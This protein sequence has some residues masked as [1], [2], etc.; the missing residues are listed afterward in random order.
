[1]A[2]ERG[3]RRGYRVATF[4][5]ENLLHPGVH[6][7]GRGDEA[8]YTPELFADKVRW[9]ASL[10]DEGRVDLVGFQ[11]LF[12][13]TAL[14][15]VVAASRRLRGA[16]V[17]TPGITGGENL[18]TRAD[19]GVEASGPH[20]GL[21]T[22]FPVL[23]CDSVEEFPPGPGVALH[24]GRAAGDGA[25]TRFQRPVLRA[26]VVLPG[27]VPATVL[28]AH[29]K[30]K[31]PVHLTGEDV[32][33]PVVQAAGRVRALLVRAA[34]AV[35]LRALV[36]ALLDGGRAGPGAGPA[37]GPVIL[38]GDLNDDLAAVTTRLVAGEEPPHHLP[39]ER[40][41]HVAGA[42]LHSAHDLQELRNYRDVSY[43]H[44]HQGR[45][46]LLDHVFVSRHFVAPFPGRVGEV[47]STRVFNDHLVDA[48]W[49]VDEARPA[50]EVGGEL[51]RLPSA[52][53]DHGMAVT[54]ILVRGDGAGGADEPGGAGGRGSAAGP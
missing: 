11:E 49:A 31:R 46:Q 20:V 41:E 53:A 50:V 24:L 45:F 43:T 33:D 3:P 47:V 28:V 42:L 34:E 51:R 8:P 35:A 16:S 7:A 23:S 39:A 37:G 12:S 14:R 2:D 10:L 30:S 44:V 9:I 52:R 6:F 29:L 54:E 38:L 27:E 5:V 19:G 25:V 32:E 48:R 36:V 26:R 1:M 17:L 15:E 4:N 21:V 22:R 18:H 40:R 13:A